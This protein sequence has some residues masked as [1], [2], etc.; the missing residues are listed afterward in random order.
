[1]ITSVA[2]KVARARKTPVRVIHDVH[3][4]PVVKFRDADVTKPLDYA[5]VRKIDVRYASDRYGSLRHVTLRQF[6]IRVLLS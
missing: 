1:M 4:P 2:C 3:T 5:R 6:L